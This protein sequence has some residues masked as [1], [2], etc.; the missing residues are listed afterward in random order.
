MMQKRPTSGMGAKGQSFIEL[1]LVLAFLL[2][3]VAGMVQLGFFMFSYL[4]ALDLTREAARFASTRDFHFAKTSQDADECNNKTLN[5]YYDTACFF[6]DPDLNPSIPISRTQ[7]ADVTIS[8]FTITD[9]HVTDRWPKP[10]ID[11]DG[12]GVWSLYNNNWKK[13]CDGSTVYTQPFFTNADIESKFQVNATRSKGLVLVEVFYCYNQI[14]DF[15]VIS[16]FI[17][18]PFRIHAYTIMPYPQAIPTPTPIA[19]P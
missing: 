11:S 5:Y 1:A 19:Y 14:L 8:V 13:D 4:T 18:S 10:P 15:P 17:P 16:R 6:T 3:L 9:N 7:Y 2:L 12:D